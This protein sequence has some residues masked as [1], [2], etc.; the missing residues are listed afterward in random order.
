MCLAGRMT[1]RITARERMLARGGLDGASGVSGGAVPPASARSTVWK[2][3]A[4]FTGQAPSG[5]VRRD[6]GSGQP[7]EGV[8]AREEAGTRYR[9]C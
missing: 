9:M 7:A 6:A 4:Y 1:G 2:H 5:T 8:R 3:P